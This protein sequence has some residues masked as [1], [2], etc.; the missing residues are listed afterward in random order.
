MDSEQFKFERKLLSLASPVYPLHTEASS[1]SFLSGLAEYEKWLDYTGTQILYIH[2]KQRVREAAEQIY[3]TLDSMAQKDG[4]RAIVLYFS[5]DR[6][7]VRC[8]SIRDML[9][10]FLAQIICHYPRLSNRVKALSTLLELERG[11]TEADLVYWFERFRFTDEIEHV[12]CVIN[13][14]DECTKGSRKPF[15]DNFSSIA[16]ATE[17]PWKVVITSHTPGALTDE[18]SGPSCAT[19]DLAESGLETYDAEGVDRLVKHLI[20]LRPELHLQ[21]S[22]LREQLQ[23]IEKADPLVRHIICEQA[24]VR[25]E[26]PDEISTSELIGSLELNP[27]ETQDVQDDQTLQKVLDWVFQKIP[28]QTT[29]QR[30]L[31]WLLYSVRPLTLSEFATIA[32]LSSDQDNESLA[33]PSSSEIE[34]FISKVQ[35]WLA[36][37]VEID[38]N[39][40]K[41]RSPRLRNI[42][43][44]SEAEEGKPR[45]LWDKI[46]FTAHSDIARLCLEYLSRPKVLEIVGE[47]LNPMELDTFETPTFTDRSTLCTYAVQAWTYHFSLGSPKTDLPLLLSHLK[48]S[49]LEKR[50][51]RAYWSLSNPVMRNPVCLESLFPIFAG[52]GLLDVVKPQNE[53]AAGQGLCEAASRGQAKIVQRLLDKVDFSES[54]L[55]DA[56]ISAGACGDEKM[57]LGLLEYIVTNSTDSKKIAWPPILIFRAAWLGLDRF[58]GKLLDL[59]C[60]ADPE[61]EW[62]KYVQASP[63]H[64]AARNAHAACVQVLIKHNA[65]VNFRA[66]YGRTPLHVVASQGLADISKILVEEGK[67]DI[68]TLDEDGFSAIYF[69]SLWGHHQVVQ[70]LLELGAD[71]N[72]R[73][74]PTDGPGKWSPLVVAA[75]DG[76]KQCVQFLLDKKANP[77]IVGPTDIGT[78]LRYAAVKGHL[79]ICELLI[80]RGAEPNSPL[81]N[82]PIL[83][84]II[85]DY[86]ATQN[87][88]EIFD[89]LLEHNADVNAKDSDGV[90]VLV[91]A[92]KSNQSDAFI[93]RLVDHDADVNILDSDNNG[94]LYHLAENGHQYL[95]ELLLE[96]GAAVNQVST[97]GTTPLYFAVPEPEVVR[98][99]LEKGADPDLGRSQGFTA[100]MFAAWFNHI[101]TLKYLLKH[102]VSLEQEYNG[103][104]EE[105]KGWTALNVSFLLDCSPR[106]T[107][108]PDCRRRRLGLNWDNLGSALSQDFIN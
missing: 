107:A 104:D 53:T 82:P 39:E 59:G 22:I 83:I 32:Y 24:R 3:H 100:L 21:E 25:P 12:M 62:M 77:N 92:A 2:G 13:Y 65:D 57:M 66:M 5:F 16:Q 33:S 98:I 14:F 19:L 95:V 30:I 96:K 51:A 64:H 1:Y 11:W 15:L 93:R 31:S 56:L 9:S 69:A 6:W 79:E 61:V 20:T 99:L 87:Q 35:V 86:T 37:I 80:A 38:H 76:F 105:L 60:S 48:S 49:D 47:F 75:D 28:D 55:L 63:L 72:M 97:G 81:I 71:P 27:T 10:T 68:E 29:L 43:M 45:Y 7:D 78:P 85:T 90:P 23:Q 17:R 73:I 50:W 108:Q 18:L 42:L 8:D 106:I 84:Q 41:V 67:S 26:W 4:K 46:K 52:L 88:L 94:A 58:A 44:G 34:S 74:E 102:N 70:A 89:L 103:D 101:D 36:G 91:H 40:V 54:V